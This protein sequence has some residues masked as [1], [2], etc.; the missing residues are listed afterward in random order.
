MR[1][2][3]PIANAQAGQAPPSTE[4]LQANG[5]NASTQFDAL[6][7]SLDHAGDVRSLTGKCVEERG[8]YQC[9]ADLAETAGCWPITDPTR[10][11]YFN[12][13]KARLANSGY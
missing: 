6:L 9:K 5:R 2:C 12:P 4:Q 13:G 7:D 8:P 3:L 11:S 10:I 1:A